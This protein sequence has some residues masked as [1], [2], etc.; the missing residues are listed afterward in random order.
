MNDTSNFLD[1]YNGSTI[2]MCVAGNL[3]L[4]VVIYVILKTKRIRKNHSSKFLVSLLFSDLLLSMTVIVV[5]SETWYTYY[6]TNKTM[7][8]MSSAFFRLLATTPLYMS[9][10][11]MLV[12]IDR[13]VA[14]K[15]PFFYTGTVRSVHVY[16][17]ILCGWS[18]GTVYLVI[19]Y[20]RPYNKSDVLIEAT[21]SFSA[22]FVL[23][24]ITLAIINTEIYI[25]TKRQIK[26][27][28][29]S[30]TVSRNQ[31]GSSKYKSRKYLNKHEIK[32]IKVC[33]GVVISYL[34][35]DCLK[36]ASAIYFIV[37]R[38]PL[39]LLDIISG[40]I[41]ILNTIFDPI[42]Y[43]VINK[44]IRKEVIRMFSIQNTNTDSN[45]SKRNRN[46]EMM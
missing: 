30:N 22:V 24:F 37:K 38:Q 35:C 11:I 43:V 18:L 3:L 25:I 1:V 8:Y 31:I 7:S 44:N 34:V 33:Y 6:K 40:Y 42:V 41:Y 17:I 14:I 19:E 39:E 29:S 9:L 32:A 2:S 10:N 5:F 23:T 16:A 27:V 21:Y 46:I 26:S 45:S 20:S 28:H 12:S 15:W 13:L 4:L 36:L